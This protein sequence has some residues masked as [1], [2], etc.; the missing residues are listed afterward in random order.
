MVLVPPIPHGRPPPFKRYHFLPPANLFSKHISLYA[1]PHA[2]RELLP[3]SYG[4]PSLPMEEYPSTYGVP[5][6]PIEHLYPMEHHLYRAPPAT[7]LD[8]SNFFLLWAHSTNGAPT[9][10]TP[11][12]IWKHHPYGGAQPA[13][14]VFLLLPKGGPP[15]KGHGP[16]PPQSQQPAPGC[17]S[18]S[19]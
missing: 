4:A 16:A 14:G 17:N 19:T 2:Y 18:R 15:A 12:S 1:S 11:F 6:L 5:L 10:R 9:Y 3:S 8:L 7:T 13:I